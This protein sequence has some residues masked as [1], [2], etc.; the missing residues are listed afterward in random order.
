MIGTNNFWDTTDES[1][2]QEMIYDSNDDIE[3]AGEI[4]YTPILED[5]D[6]ETPQFDE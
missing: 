1:T 4:S 5:P 3:S 2:V 6:S